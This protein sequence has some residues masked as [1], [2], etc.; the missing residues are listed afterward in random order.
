MSPKLKLS[1]NCLLLLK[2]LIPDNIALVNNST[3]DNQTYKGK[4]KKIA[5]R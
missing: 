1:A 3:C 5:Q 4:A 2:K